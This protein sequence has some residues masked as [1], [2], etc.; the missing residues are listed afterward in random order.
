M[1]EGLSCQLVSKLQLVFILIITIKNKYYINKLQ[2]AIQN[3]MSYVS[4][5]LC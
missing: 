1:A 4:I 2:T 3:Q 5:K